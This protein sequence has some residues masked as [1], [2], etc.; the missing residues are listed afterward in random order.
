[1]NDQ[2]QLW[3]QKHARGEHLQY[4]LDEPRD[5]AA[6]VL[7]DLRSGTRL[8]ELGCG[9]GND[10][11]F[12]ARNGIEVLSTDFSEV[13]V[14]QNIEYGVQGN[15]Q[16]EVLDMTGVFPYSD[17]CFDAVYAHLA[18]HYFDDEVTANIIKEV[19]RVLKQGGKFYFIC[20]STKDPKYG[21]GEQIGPNS[22]EC[23]G[24][25]RHFFSINHTKELLK[26]IF[27]VER[28]SESSAIYTGE[29]SAF[30]ECWATKKGA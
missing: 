16:F 4:G 15:L 21:Q 11:R 22:F 6:P 9:V 3:N 7:A 10:A 23:M 27:D 8:L 19:A 20:K 14:Q 18:I 26:D 2:R 1:M 24:H 30:I 12:F 17:S 29:P 13:V 28:L 25:I 5:F